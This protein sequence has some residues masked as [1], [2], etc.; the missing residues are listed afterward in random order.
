VHLPSSLL[1]LFLFLERLAVPLV[2]H[3]SLL[4]VAWVAGTRIFVLWE[5][6]PNYIILELVLSFITNL[7]L[8]LAASSLL[9]I[10]LPKTRRLYH[11]WLGRR[12]R[13][14]IILL[15]GLL[16]TGFIAD[17]KVLAKGNALIVDLRRSLR[18]FMG[19]SLVGSGAIGVLSD[20][21]KIVR[22]RIVI[23]FIYQKNSR[24]QPPPS[25]S[26]RSQTAKFQ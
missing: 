17:T 25:E 16:I 7:G 19:G 10:I 15:N 26:I 6:L 14:A 18:E 24:G 5:M 4:D 20:F 1:D 3:T 22:H 12:L 2:E 13:L 9:G 8:D 21:R 23:I 11:R